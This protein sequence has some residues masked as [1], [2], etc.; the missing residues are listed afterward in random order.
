MIQC[1][2]VTA[3]TGLGTRYFDQPEIIRVAT[4]L[5]NRK[6]SRVRRRA[7]RAGWHPLTDDFQAL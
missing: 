2:I 7:V 4:K 5:R 1:L 6:E 3:M